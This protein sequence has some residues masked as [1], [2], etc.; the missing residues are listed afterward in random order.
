MRFWT[1]ELAGW[2][3]IILGLFVFWRCYQF[4]TDGNHYLIEAGTMTAIGVILFR[5]GIHLLKVAV[6]AQACLEADARL[7]AKP[8]TSRPTPLRGPSKSLIV[9]R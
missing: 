7:D 9:R 6:A 2:V 3:L 8:Q 5:G 1:R 4:L